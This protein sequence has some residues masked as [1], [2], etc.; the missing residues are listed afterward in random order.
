MLRM[1]AHLASRCRMR[2]QGSPMSCYS[3]VAQ[4][5]EHNQ[6]SLLSAHGRVAEGAEGVER[7]GELL[8]MTVR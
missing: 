2:V 8:R 5:R 1:S 3:K 6:A 7:S 4:G